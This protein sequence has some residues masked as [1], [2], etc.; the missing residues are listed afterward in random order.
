LAGAP[1]AQAAKQPRLVW[2]WKKWPAKNGL[3]SPTSSGKARGQKGRGGK[4][5]LPAELGCIPIHKI[6]LEGMAKILHLLSRKLQGSC[7]HAGNNGNEDGGGV[8]GE[9]AADDG[10][11]GSMGRDRAVPNRPL[12]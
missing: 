12:L 9:A 11:G 4:A 8:C 10:G 7:M 6:L 5:T 3:L 1:V 2:R